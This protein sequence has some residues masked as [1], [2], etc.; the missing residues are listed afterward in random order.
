[1]TF[2]HLHTFLFLLGLCLA[3]TACKKK[4]VAEEDDCYCFPEDEY[5]YFTNPDVTVW[6]PYD[7]SEQL[8]FEDSQGDSLI[9]I[10]VEGLVHDTLD[11]TFRVCQHP[12]DCPSYKHLYT[13]RMIIQFTSPGIPWRF[14]LATAGAGSHL[15]LDLFYWGNV[16]V[17]RDTFVGPGTNTSS[18]YGGHTVNYYGTLTLNG[19]TYTD[20]YGFEDAVN[21]QALFYKMGVGI[22]GF[23]APDGTGEFYVLVP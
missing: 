14:K 2:K 22:V 9:F 5:D 3:L 16:D 1:M 20:V 23:K 10:A 11:E 19:Q 17:I 21:N 12:Q 13:E 8:K 18:V 7:G 4:E 6:Q 15:S